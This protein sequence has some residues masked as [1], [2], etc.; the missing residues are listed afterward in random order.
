MREEL[1]F[2]CDFLDVARMALYS[3]FSEQ[4]SEWTDQS[5]STSRFEAVK[6]FLLNNSIQDEKGDSL[7]FP[8]LLVE[9]VEEAETM[10]QVRAMIS[11]SNSENTTKLSE[12]RWMER[13][14]VGKFVRRENQFR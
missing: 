3:P 9:T 7:I 6:R 1:P 14:K 13:M 2:T 5:V 4:R 10:K 12:G 11:S 8:G